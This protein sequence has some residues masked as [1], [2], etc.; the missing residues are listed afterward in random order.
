MQLLVEDEGHA[1]GGTTVRSSTALQGLDGKGESVQMIW[2]DR[3]HA[4]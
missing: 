1:V 4:V 2:V 3:A